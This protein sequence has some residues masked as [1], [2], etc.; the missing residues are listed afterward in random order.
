MKASIMKL[1][2][3]AFAGCLFL[4][5]GT[6]YADAPLK[7]ALG[8][9]VEQAA[10]VA[11]IEEQ[12]RDAIRPLRTEL[13]REERALRRARLAD[14]SQA[15]AKQEALIEPLRR[16]FAAIHEAETKQIRAM[17]T[18]EQN[19]KYDKWLKTRDEMAGSSRDVKEYQEQK[20]AGQ[21]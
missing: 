20:T 14:D 9:D 1:I 19:T 15:I 18:P 6:A 7:S 2:T 16:K 21:K 4:L 17:L 8:L 12:A 13:N 11:K 10:Q 5:A 3:V